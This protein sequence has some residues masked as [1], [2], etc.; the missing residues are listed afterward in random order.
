MPHFFR[1]SFPV[2]FEDIM[3]LSGVCSHLV[4]LEWEPFVRSMASSPW[5]SSLVRWLGV[6]SNMLVEL[7]VDCAQT[8]MLGI[9]LY[10]LVV[11]CFLFCLRTQFNFILRSSSWNGKPCVCPRCFCTSSY[12]AS[13]RFSM[14]LRF[15]CV[16]DVSTTSSRFPKKTC[17][18]YTEDTAPA[19]LIL[20]LLCAVFFILYFPC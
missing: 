10:T 18:G 7:I 14:F 3:H 4:E 20:H 15:L 8:Q 2:L 9:R 11:W 16:F 13:S 17:I 19:L 12:R 6:V 1:S 5:Q